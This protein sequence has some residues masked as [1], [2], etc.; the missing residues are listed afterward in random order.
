MRDAAE[1]KQGHLTFSVREGLN[2]RG[3]RG[4]D[5]LTNQFGREIRDHLARRFRRRYTSVAFVGSKGLHIDQGRIYDLWRGRQGAEKGRREENET[6]ANL[7]TGT[8]ALFCS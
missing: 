1:V 7:M 8:I 6:T 5:D 3:D 2:G 4:F